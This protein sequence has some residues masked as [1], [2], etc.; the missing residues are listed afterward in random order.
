MSNIDFISQ[1]V[2]TVINEFATRDPFE[3]CEQLKIRI[4]FKDLG[5]SLKAYFF[6]QSRIKNIVINSRSDDK[7]CRVLCAHELGHAILHHKLFLLKGFH[8]LNL[9]DSI[10]P[11]EYEANLFAA[12][13]LISDGELLNLI[14]DGENTIFDIAKKLQVPFELIS[15]KIRILNQ[16]GYKFENFHIAQSNFLKRDLLIEDVENEN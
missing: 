1:K 10:V 16:K 11:T 15:F 7:L 9:F 12:E 8:E 6:Y 4:Y 3:I 13:L 2:F 14:Y 5:P